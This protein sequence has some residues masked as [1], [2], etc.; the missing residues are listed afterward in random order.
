MGDF[1]TMETAA[2]RQTYVSAKF[3]AGITDADIAKPVKLV[4]ADTYGLCSAGDPIEGFIV[5]LNPDTKAGLPFGTVQTG[6]YKRVEL[7]GAVT[8]GS[9][10]A[11][12]TSAAAGTAE[13]NGLGKVQLHEV[14]DTSALTVF[15][16]NWKLVSGTGLDGDTTAVIF[17]L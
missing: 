4:A 8:I 14:T 2:N 3:E 6:G 17:K 10:V 9:L 16:I 7:D 1:K 13:A 15:P 11:A 12:G 5:G